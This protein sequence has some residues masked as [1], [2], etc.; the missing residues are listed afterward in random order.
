[1]VRFRWDQFR[2]AT[3]GDLHRHV[4]IVALVACAFATFSVWVHS[5]IVFLKTC[6]ARNASCYE[7]SDG[8]ASV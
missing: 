2:D 5:I 6:Q 4:A 1:M 3:V 7:Q 8:L